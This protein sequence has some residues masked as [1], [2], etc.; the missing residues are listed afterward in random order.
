MSRNNK[1][2]QIYVQRNF[3]KTIC[4]QTGKFDIYDK[5]EYI[6]KLLKKWKNRTINLWLQTLILILMM[7]IVAARKK[8]M[9]AK[10]REVC[11]FLPL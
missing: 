2:P 11:L 1:V 10:C 3:S 9:V 8:M 6:K 7:R 4:T 5:N